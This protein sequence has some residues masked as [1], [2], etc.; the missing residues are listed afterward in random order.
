[1]T[2]GGHLSSARGGCWASARGVERVLGRARC[3]AAANASAGG[4]RVLGRARCWAAANASAGGVRVLGR[5]LLS[6]QICFSFFQP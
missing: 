6:G 3:W 2:G 5:E 1:M 4:V